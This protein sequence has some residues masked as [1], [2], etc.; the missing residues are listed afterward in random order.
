MSQDADDTPPAVTG[1]DEV[2]AALAALDGLDER[3]LG[4]QAAALEA[5]HET[6]RAVLAG[7]GESSP[8]SA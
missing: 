3:P 1:H 5:T 2:D 7:A 6:L 8:G 4:E